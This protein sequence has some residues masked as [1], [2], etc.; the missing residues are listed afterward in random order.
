MKRNKYLLLALCFY[1]LHSPAMAEENPQSPGFW[2]TLPEVMLRPMGVVASAAGVA[3]FVAG[4]PFTALASIPEP[5]DA[6]TQTFDAFVKTPYRLTFRRPLGDYRLE[7]G[8]AQSDSSIASL[9]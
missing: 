3:F 2:D 9:D 6:F 1:L 8:E 7:I 5:H 4:S